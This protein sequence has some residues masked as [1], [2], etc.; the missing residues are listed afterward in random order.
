MSGL[1]A[2]S[3]KPGKIASGAVFLGGIGLL[4][5]SYFLHRGREKTGHKIWSLVE[6]ET[7][8]RKPG[9]RANAAAVKDELRNIIT[10]PV[11]AEGHLSDLRSIVQTQNRSVGTPFYL[12]RKL[13]GKQFNMPEIGEGSVIDRYRYI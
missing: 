4:G 9:L 7:L 8:S 5:A 10:H 3:S 6:Q 2:L 11:Y 1:S 12:E 13:N